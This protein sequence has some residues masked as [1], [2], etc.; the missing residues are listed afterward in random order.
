M[1]FMA[2][3]VALCAALLLVWPA[4]ATEDQKD[5]AG[6]KEVSVVVEEGQ[7]PSGIDTPPIQAAPPIEAAPPAE[8]TEPGESAEGTE[9]SE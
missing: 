1:R 9:L 8:D 3:M 4:A 7:L 5:E 6:D 2:W